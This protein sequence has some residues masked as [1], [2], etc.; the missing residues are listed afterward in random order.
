MNSLSLPSALLLLACL[1]PLSQ[2][3]STG[4][5]IEACVQELDGLLEAEPVPKSI[6]VQT[7]ILRQHHPS[8]ALILIG[9]PEPEVLAAWAQTEPN[10][11]DCE[12]FVQTVQGLV[13]SVKC[14]ANIRP[15]LPAHTKA[16]ARGQ[17]LDYALASIGACRTRNNMLEEEEDEE[18][19][20]A[21]AS[22]EEKAGQQS[23][24]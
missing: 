3:A 21:E 9:E 14:G 15:M 23:D 24:E 8:E 13:Q 1:A 16:M 2:A 5:N 17:W 22:V 19:D 18:E 6:K 10:P 7:E 4:F 12:K 20:E 11:E